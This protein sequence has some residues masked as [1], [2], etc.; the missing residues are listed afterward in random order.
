MSDLVDAIVNDFFIH[1]YNAIKNEYNCIRGP[2]Q[3]NMHFLRSRKANRKWWDFFYDEEAYVYI[4]FKGLCLAN[5]QYHVIMEQRHTIINWKK[6][7]GVVD[8][9]I[10]ATEQ[11]DE[12][13]VF[14]EVKSGFLK[15]M[16]KSELIED[17]DKL[18]HLEHVP[19]GRLRFL[20][21]IVVGPIEDSLCRKI[22]EKLGYETYRYLDDISLYISE[23]G[24]VKEMRSAVA[25]IKVD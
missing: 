9:E 2:L 10:C 4:I 24:G 3:R 21:L 14:I 12:P 1:A 11:S 18:R 7:T 13:I 23:N 16:K 25:L 19:A 5:F 20:M 8:I 15:D 17:M 6:K 22:E